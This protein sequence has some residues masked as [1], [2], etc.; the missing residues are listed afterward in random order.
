MAV[1]SGFALVTGFGT[2]D[3]VKILGKRAHTRRYAFI[4]EPSRT[5]NFGTGS[6]IYGVQN[7]ISNL[8]KLYFFGNAGTA[9]MIKF[10][11]VTVKSVD[12]NILARNDK[13]ALLN[14]GYGAI[15]SWV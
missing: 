4:A 8:T 10:D 6:P 11:G 12:Q 7:Q 1:R 5:A 13:E 15:A 9:L 2:A 14:L 3:L